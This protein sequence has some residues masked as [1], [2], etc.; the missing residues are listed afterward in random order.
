MSDERLT[1]RVLAGLKETGVRVTLDDFGT[2]YSSALV[3]A[4]F[5]FDTLK[6]DRSFVERIVQGRKE[7]AVTAAIIRLA[8]EIGL[9]VVVE[10]VE[11]PA[12]LEC[13]R[14]LGA[15]ENPGLPVR[16]APARGRLRGLVSRRLRYAVGRGLKGGPGARS[17][18][19]ADGA[20]A[21]PGASMSPRQGDARRRRGV[22]AARQRRRRGRPADHRGPLQCARLQARPRGR[23]DPAQGTGGGAVGA[24]RGQPPGLPPG[25]GAHR[26]PGAGGGP[27]LRARLVHLGAHHHRRRGRARAGLATLDDKPYDEVDTVIALDHLILAAASLGLGTCWVAAFDLAAAREVLGLPADV[28]PIA[29]TPLG[30][31][32]KPR[33]ATGRKPLEQLVDYERW[34]AS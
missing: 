5:P 7:R 12:Q 26:R 23:R 24:H 19:P 28:E 27:Y 9:S 17:P 15:D 32:D 20:G 16:P 22:R 33:A 31:P 6:V 18:G 29:F 3:L 10:G 14:E 34:S 25:R 13:M 2:G 11:T 8:H 4:K 21:Y 1:A 30:W